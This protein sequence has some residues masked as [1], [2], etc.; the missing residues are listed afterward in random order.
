MREILFRG[1]RVDNGEW[2]EGFFTK[3]GD[4]TFILIDN[5]FAVGYVK[6]KEVIPETVGQYT[7]LT[8]K[9]GKKIFEGDIVAEDCGWKGLVEFFTED[10]GSCGCC[11]PQFDG[12]G[13]KAKYKNDD[14]GVDMRSCTIVG[15]IYDNPEMWEVEK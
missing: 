6:M 7:G 8:D 3:S 12:S 14:S 15:N 1:K 11:V 13:F 4:R 10:I 5:D 9:N 2:V